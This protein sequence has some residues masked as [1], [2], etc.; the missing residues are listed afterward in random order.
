M[1][2][3][4]RSVLPGLVLGIIA[5]VAYAQQPSGERRARGGR[6]FGRS[7]RSVDRRPVIARRALLGHREYFGVR[8]RTRARLARLDPYRLN[9]VGMDALRLL[10][11]S[12]KIPQ[13]LEEIVLRLFRKSSRL[14]SPSFLVPSS[15]PPCIR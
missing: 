12:Q 15:A 5:A 14:Y 10:H 4:R 8:Q 1:N 3:A 6:D 9:I 2:T 13:S 11:L 7:L